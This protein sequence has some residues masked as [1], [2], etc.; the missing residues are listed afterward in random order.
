MS[1]ANE[2]LTGSE[3]AGA[4][5]LLDEAAAEA[6][7][8]GIKEPPRRRKN[9]IHSNTEA[10]AKAGFSAPIAAGE[11]TIAVAM[12][13]MVDRFGERFL[14]GGG[15]EVALVKPV[16]FGDRIVPRA[17]VLRGGKERIEFEIWVDNQD[18]ARVLTGAASVRAADQ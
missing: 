17:R 14:R 8:R 12:Q 6:Y 3:F 11:H 1:T 2:T 18:G 4:P 15:F 10:A 7:G 13:L 16:F 5:Y 9:N